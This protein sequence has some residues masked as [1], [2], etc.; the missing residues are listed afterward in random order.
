MRS[1]RSLAPLAE[2]LY[3]KNLAIENLLVRRPN[4]LLDTSDVHSVIQRV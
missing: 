2:F 4:T 1:L 3:V